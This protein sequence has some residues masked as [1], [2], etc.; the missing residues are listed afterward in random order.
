MLLRAT[1]FRVPCPRDTASKR[2]LGNRKS[3]VYPSQ[4]VFSRMIPFLANLQPIISP[5]NHAA[6]AYPA[7]NTPGLVPDVAKKAKLCKGQSSP[8]CS[9]KMNALV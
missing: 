8:Q 6:A 2:G 9:D 4:T 3:L 1:P 5:S 7:P